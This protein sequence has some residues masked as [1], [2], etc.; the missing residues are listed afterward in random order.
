MQSDAPLFDY[1]AILKTADLSTLSHLSRLPQA[2]VRAYLKANPHVR[3]QGNAWTLQSENAAQRLAALAEKTPAVHRQR[4]QAVLTHLLSQHQQGGAVDED[5]T[6][7]IFEQLT[8]PLLRTDPAQLEPYI[9]IMV[10]LTWQTD[11]NAQKTAFY[12]AVI[13]RQQGAID[14]AIGRFQALLAL[15]ALDAQVQGR[16]LNSLAICYTLKG[17]WAQA[18]ASYRASLMHWQ[19]NSNAL[20]A[21]TVRFNLGIVAYKLRNYDEAIANLQQAKRQFIEHEQHAYVYAVQSELAIVYRD[22]GEWDKAEAIFKTLLAHFEEAGETESLGATLL[23]LGEIQLFMGDLS[24]AQKNLN[25]GVAML[26]SPAYKIDGF[27]HLGLSHLASQSWG[28][29]EAMFLAAKAVCDEM[30]RG[31]SLPEIFYQ[32]GQL[33]RLRG[34]VETALRHLETAASLIEA[35]RQPVQGEALKISLLGRWQQVFEALVL[36]HADQGNATAAFAWAER[37]RARAFADTLRRSETVAELQTVQQRLSPDTTVFC[38]FTTGVLENDMPMLRNIPTDNPLRPHLLLPAETLCFAISATR[39]KLKRCGLDPN[40]FSAHSPRGFDVTQLMKTVVLQRLYQFLCQYDER[41]V[42]ENKLIV[43]PHGPLHRVPF[44]AVLDAGLAHTAQLRYAPSCTLL[45]DDRKSPLP[46]SDALVVAYNG[47]L[48]RNDTPLRYTEAEGRDVIQ[49]L[50][51]E[52]L[53]GA[54]P[55]KSRLRHEA[56]KRAWLHFACHGF[57]DTAQ[58]LNSY[59]QTGAG[60]RLAAQEIMEA[61]RLEAR[62][63]VLSACETA[64]SQMLRGDEPMG[65]IRAFLFAGAEAV[66]ATQWPVDDFATALLM[67][68]FYRTLAADPAAPLAQTLVEAQSW[69]KTA[70]ATQLTALAKE[71]DLSP[72]PDLADPIPFADPLYWAG[73]QL[74]G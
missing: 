47:A 11:V 39:C 29:A 9:Q 62:L 69:L 23:N 46:P 21:A 50:G 66:L 48:E 71:M 54:E 41:D 58:P 55:K 49:L 53:A 70:D 61:W 52:L 27:L 12:H 35:S 73:F 22:L 24:A 4:H 19:T 59:L 36:L 6:M 3:K 25:T 65:L 31:E 60:E 64:V 30:D 38:Y 28:E 43:V 56:A 18:F 7:A 40:L 74:V 1:L 34:N 51:G 15:P 72:I 57:F 32:L 26:H 44:A 67:G 45:R 63:V 16:A 37:S 33:E 10:E 42:I 2:D 20:Q 5:L 68:R 14:E 17:A 8:N 13:L